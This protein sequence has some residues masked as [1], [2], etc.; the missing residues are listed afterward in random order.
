MPE[1][2]EVETVSRGLKRWAVGRRVT[3]IEVRHPEAVAGP[4]ETLVSRSIVGV[5][6]KGKV[7]ALELDAASDGERRYLMVRLGMTG[8]LTVQPREA[9]LEPHTHVRLMLDDGSMEL[10]YR[11]V[12]RFGKLRFCTPADLESVLGRLGPD[13]QQI[14]GKDFLRAMRGRRGAMKSWLMNQQALAGLGNIYADEALFESRV[15]PLAQPGRIARGAARRLFR[16]VQRVLKRAVERQG[17]SFRDYVD[18]E[19]R[20]GDFLMKLKVYQ[21]TGRPCRRCGQPIRRIVVAGR[22][23]HFCPRCQPRPR[24]VAKMRGPLKSYERGRRSDS[25]SSRR[26]T[27]RQGALPAD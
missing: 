24:Q 14:T 10:R 1:L 2:P 22:S 12:R 16:A 8:Q 26:Q 23:S 11:D 3:G 19:G 15:H 21:R 25:R 17:T 7:L 27:G 5:R 9:P 6:R 18:I 4:V 13:A 20:P